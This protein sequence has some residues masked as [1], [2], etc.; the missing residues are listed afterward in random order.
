MASSGASVPPSLD[1]QCPSCNRRFDN[2]VSV[3]RHMNHP[4]TSCATWFDLLESV[5]PPAQHS[6]SHNELNH[7]PLDNNTGT[8]HNEENTLDDEPMLEDDTIG[9]L[10]VPR[11]EDIHPNTPQVLGSGAGFTEVFNSDHHAEKRRTNLYH[12]FSSK[13]EWGLAS[14]LLRSGLSMRATDDFLSLPLVRTKNRTAD[15]LLIKNQGPAAITFLHDCE[16]TLQ[17][18]GRPSQGTRLENAVGFPRQVQDCKT[19][20]PLLLRPPRSH[21]RSPSK[22]DF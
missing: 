6:S 15:P 1:G 3:L 7:T 14:W 12:P 10:D 18:H 5:S 20:H 11:Y 17:S 16:N 19:S 8:S 22:P 9:N 21:P 13:E 2:N 4:L